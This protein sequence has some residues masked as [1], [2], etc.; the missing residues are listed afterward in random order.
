MYAS[1]QDCVNDLDKSGQLLRIKTPLDP[2]L[3][4]A[5]VH[6][7]IFEAGG[8]AILFENVIGSPFRGLS[9][10][11]GTFERTDWLFRK[12]LEKVHNQILAD[13][14]WSICDYATG[15]VASSR[16]KKYDAI[17]SRYVSNPT[18]WK[19]LQNQ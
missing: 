4:I 14:W 10:I 5:E 18:D 11:Y 19:R 3:E 12:T 16:V 7:R 17:E 15:N 2:N 6:R 1:L 13:G 8:P 9:N